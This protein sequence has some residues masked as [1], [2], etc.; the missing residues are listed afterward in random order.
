MWTSIQESPDHYHGIPMQRE[1]IPN[2]TGEPRPFAAFFTYS[3]LL[4]CSTIATA[5]IFDGQAAVYLFMCFLLAPSLVAASCMRMMRQKY[6]NPSKLPGLLLGAAVATLYL[7]LAGR[8]SASGVPPVEFLHVAGGFLLAF[9]WH[10]VSE[11]AVKFLIWD[12]F[13]GSS[14]FDE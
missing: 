14:S 8:A 12:D 13:K 5:Y 1:D 3:V 10:R 2:S 9:A 6:N 4:V 7:K 11:T